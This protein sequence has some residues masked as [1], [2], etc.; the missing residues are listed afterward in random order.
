MVWNFVFQIRWMYHY[1]SMFEKHAK[2]LFKK[3]KQ[4]QLF[5]N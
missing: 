1:S 2:Q 3:K 5:G 4:F